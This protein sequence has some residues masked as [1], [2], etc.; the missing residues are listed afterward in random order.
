MEDHDLRLDLGM[1]CRCCDYHSYKLP[2]LECFPAS[3][4]ASQR[5]AVEDLCKLCVDNFKQSTVNS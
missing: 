5:Q 2:E 3:F 4:P 1:L